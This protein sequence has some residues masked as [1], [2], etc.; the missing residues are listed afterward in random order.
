MAK[1]EKE[2]EKEKSASGESMVNAIA[3][4]I[5]TG[6]QKRVYQSGDKLTEM[7][8]CNQY[9]V[10]RTPVREAFRLLQQEGLLVHI[11]RCGVVVASIGE[12]EM[13]DVLEI[14]ARLEQYSSGLAARYA[15]PKDIVALRKM[16]E[17]ICEAVNDK[18]LN[19]S[20]LDEEFH[21][22]IARLGRNNIL[23]E[24]LSSLYVKNRIRDYMYPIT[25][26]RLPHTWK[27]H[28]DIILA[29]EVNDPEL[30]EKYMDIHFHNSRLSNRK[31]IKDL[32]E[33]GKYKED[34]P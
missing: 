9:G 17:K 27:E 2:K 3:D 1:S 30:A 15:T 21:L 11:P 26:E 8:L 7:E 20:Y 12:K 25:A 4:G 23:A 29:M 24:T 13:F 32:K 14:R 34:H 19:T 5:R 18:N 31:K 28:E 16:N 22:Y 10:S 33:V 6:I